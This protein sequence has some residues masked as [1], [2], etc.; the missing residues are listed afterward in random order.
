MRADFLART[1]VLGHMVYAD[2]RDNT[3]SSFVFVEKNLKNKEYSLA[4]ITKWSD[5]KAVISEWME[6]PLDLF[7]MANIKKTSEAEEKRELVYVINNYYL[8]NTFRILAL[9]DDSIMNEKKYEARLYLDI[10]L[11]TLLN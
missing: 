7:G 2:V 10:A 3:Y 9:V 5:V 1:G 4:R 6:I 11:T 8:K